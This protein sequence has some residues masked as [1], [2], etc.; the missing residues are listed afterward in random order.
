MEFNPANINLSGL[1]NEVTELLNDSARQ[2]SITISKEIQEGLSLFADRLMINTVLRNIISNAVKYTNIGGTINI[3]AVL[4]EKQLE[5]AVKDNGVGIKTEAL[6]KLFHIEE[7][8]STPGTQDEEGTGLGLILCRD[9]VLK[10]GGEIW[11]ESEPGNGSRFV[12]T[13]PV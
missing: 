6:K 2:K 5:I 3:S 12:F 7:S 1:V 9:F 11:S 10:H 13:I 4:R 8:I